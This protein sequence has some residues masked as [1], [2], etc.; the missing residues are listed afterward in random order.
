MEADGSQEPPAR[1]NA[2]NH[3]E[4][5]LD[6]LKEG[7]SFSSFTPAGYLPSTNPNT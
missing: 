6:E 5:G 1:R 4:C 3:Q 7:G 2:L